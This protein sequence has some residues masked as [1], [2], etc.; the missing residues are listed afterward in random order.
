MTIPPSALLVD[1]ASAI[2]EQRI[3][4]SVRK[5]FRHELESIL[6]DVGGGDLNWLVLELRQKPEHAPVWQALMR[7]LTI[8]ETYFFRDEAAFNRL[9]Q[10]ILPDL[11]AARRQQEQFELAIWSAGCATGEEAYSIAI[12]LH[13]ILADRPRWKIRLVA[14]DINAQALEQ[15]RQGI[16]RDWAFRHNTDRL[17]HAYFD[18]VEAGWQIKPFLR[19]MVQFELGNLLNPPAAN[20]DLI[21][22]RN[23]LIYFDQDS[24]F[25]L[26]DMLYNAL[27]PAGW[28]A[29][30]QSEAIRGDRDRWLKTEAQASRWYQKPARTGANTS[31]A[32]NRLPNPQAANQPTADRFLQA[33]TA[34]YHEQADEA[35]RILHDLLAENPQHTRAHILLASLMASRGQLSQAHQQ[36]DAALASDPLLGDAHY[37]RAIL[38]MEEEQD[39][40][41]SQALRSALY[42]QRDHLLS[43]FMLG[44]LYAKRGETSRALREW[45]KARQTAD[46][47]PSDASISDL[48]DMTAA[49]FSLLV[50]SQIDSLHY[51]S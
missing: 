22:C 17:Q 2:I 10:H 49:S 47:L 12:L 39:E 13:E 11:I 41:A 15:G 5:Q 9:R 6:L 19:Q 50:A 46:A 40:L 35:E 38:F 16:Y 24:V 42:C 8:G 45:E 14:S 33:K 48:S 36:L 37:L 23:V 31:E 43:A 20:F 21:L 4:L 32:P 3:G 51:S 34:L 25:R 30:G 29:L 18:P 28:L 7:A 27:N 1:E 44:T 26:E